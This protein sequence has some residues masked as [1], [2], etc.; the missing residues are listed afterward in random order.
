MTEA[1]RWLMFSHLPCLSS[2]HLADNNSNLGYEHVRN[3]SM[4]ITIKC[5]RRRNQLNV[6]F[7]GLVG[8]NSGLAI[9]SGRTTSSI[10]SE[11]LWA[12]L[13]K[14][15]KQN[16]FGRSVICVIIRKCLKPK[17]VSDVSFFPTKSNG[18]KKTAMNTH[19]KNPRDNC[20]DFHS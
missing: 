2:S 6:S 1:L 20:S 12:S 16:K 7:L 9:T 4:S 3:S 18:K 5:Q 19:L 10:P 8:W 15:W 17:G 14:E 13:P 11:F